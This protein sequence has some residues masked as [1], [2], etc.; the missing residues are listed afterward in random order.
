MFKVVHLVPYD[1][2]GGVETAARSMDAVEDD[3]VNF[4]V[5]YI[6]KNET[7]LFRPWPI[8]KAAK[9]LVENKPDMLIISLWRSCIVGLLVKVFRP[10]LKLV[11]FLHS[12]A[13]AHFFDQ[14]LT[15]ISVYF[16]SQV[17][18]DS[19]E[20]LSH[21]V[22]SLNLENGRIVSFVTH[23][24]AAPEEPRVIPSFI[25][26]GRVHPQKGLGHALHIFAAIHAVYPAAK[27]SIIGPDGGDLERIQKLAENLKL[28]ESVTFYGG[29]EFEEIES[30]ACDASFYLQTSLV[31]GMAMSV[32]EAM[33]LG[34]V[35]VVTPVGEIGN[36]CQHG[37]NSLLVN[38]DQCVIDEILAV[39]CSQKKYSELREN[40]IATWADQALYSE[41][42]LQAC[43]ALLLD[44]TGESMRGL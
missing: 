33:Q 5:K 34:L 11:M 12:P 6:F 44:Q 20:T 23:R 35:P 14:V 32:V 43:G 41:S 36:Y 19:K 18:A 39:L 38:A 13:D 10:R 29:R 37:E 8:L 15:R 21:R 42:V 9:Q 40:A 7:Q 24:L 22:P 1:G 4:Q 30:L 17:W 28:A 31:E 25:F 2:I 27:F 3:A 16:S 26:W